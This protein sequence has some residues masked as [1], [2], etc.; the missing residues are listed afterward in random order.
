MDSQGALDSLRFSIDIEGTGV[1]R[2]EEDIDPKIVDELKR[3]GHE[4]LVLSGY[5]RGTFG[6]GQV[7]SRNPETGVLVAGSEPRKDGMAVGW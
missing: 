5:D 2:V 6:G 4:V 3:R 1:V 7:I